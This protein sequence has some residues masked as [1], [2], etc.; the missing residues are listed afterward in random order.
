[1]A[2]ILLWFVLLFCKEGGVKIIG[3]IPAR[4]ASSRFPGKPLADI[5]G[6]PMIWWV[7]ENAK[8][9]Q[10]LTELIVATDDSRIAK[11]CEAYTMP[12]V[13][14]SDTHPTAA[15]RM[16]EVSENYEADY[17][18]CINGDEPLLPAEAIN[19]VVPQ[20][21]PQDIPFGTNVISQ[22]TNP[23]E[24]NDISNIKVA[25]DKDYNALY[26]SRSPIPTP[27]RTLNY[28]YYKHVGVLGY[29]KAMLDLYRDTEPGRFESIEGIDTLRF[30]DYGARL[31]FVEVAECRSL[32]V[33]T[34][35]DLDKVR[36]ILSKP[37]MESNIPPPASY[38]LVQE[39]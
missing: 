16:S 14:T 29:N 30:L 15:N 38:L 5:H 17:Y 26:M 1:V 39:R 35:K 25:F 6:K 23:A 27:F 11:I 22:M 33:D 34:P 18:V 2:E 37:K 8:Q 20:V 10:K 28:K 19:A 13:M 21:I 7:F 36:E 32:S 12:F 31:K 4:Y 24:V 9:S 3:I